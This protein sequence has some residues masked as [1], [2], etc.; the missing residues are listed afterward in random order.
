[1]EAAIAPPCP[2]CGGAGGGPHG[3]AGR[4]WDVEDWVCPRCK[5]TGLSIVADTAPVSSDGP[6]VAKGA[7]VAPPAERAAVRKS[8]AEK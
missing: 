6:G 4:A 1:M 8:A 3:R 5:G 2:S 7:S